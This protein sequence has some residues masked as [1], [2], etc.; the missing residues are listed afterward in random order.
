MLVKMDAYSCVFAKYIKKDYK[1]YRV[2]GYSK[3]VEGYI[4]DHAVVWI[5]NYCSY[6]VPVTVFKDN[7]IIDQF[8]V[9]GYGSTTKMYLN[10]SS[11][12]L[13]V[14]VTAPNCWV[15]GSINR[16][17]AVWQ[18][19]ERVI[20]LEPPK[21]QGASFIMSVSL[22]RV[23]GDVTFVVGD[24]QY[25]NE[26]IVVKDIS[27]AVEIRAMGEG[28]FVGTVCYAIKSLSIP[29]PSIVIT[30]DDVCEEDMSVCNCPISVYRKP[31]VYPRTGILKVEYEE[32]DHDQ[33]QTLLQI[34]RLVCRG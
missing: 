25:L 4:D 28:V 29:G 16:A 13:S 17:I 23:Y 18:G 30:N 14:W 31:V 19:M 24:S 6:P 15:S 9:P 7:D 34:R 21:I 32:V 2:S 8:E 33:L 26:A 22:V 10:L 5:E 27:D 11:G 1:E 20:R 12:V 3:L